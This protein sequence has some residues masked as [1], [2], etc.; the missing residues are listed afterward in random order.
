MIERYIHTYK[1]YIYVMVIIGVSLVI[2]GNII[3]L[4]NCTAGVVVLGI[5]VGMC[6]AAVAV[7]FMWYRAA[8][9]LLEYAN[10]LEVVEMDSDKDE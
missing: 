3:H 4:Y 6:A 10:V 5:S 2:I 8:I 9:R 1:L 7:Y